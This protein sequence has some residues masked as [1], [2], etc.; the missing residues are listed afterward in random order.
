[1]ITYGFTD[2]QCGLV[3]ISRNEQGKCFI[4]FEKVPVGHSTAYH[5]S[6]N[7]I[8]S[9]KLAKGLI[10]NFKWIWNN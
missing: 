4:S 8:Q 3:I 7:M 2:E 10:A 5:G 6:V 1:M 9:I